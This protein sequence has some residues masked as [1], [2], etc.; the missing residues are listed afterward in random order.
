[1]SLCVVLLKI[2]HTLLGAQGGRYL[3]RALRGAERRR[4]GGKTPVG[5]KKNP[6]F[7]APKTTTLSLSNERHARSETRDFRARVALILI[8]H[9]N[10]RS[11]IQSPLVHP[12]FFVVSFVKNPFFVREKHARA[13]VFRETRRRKKSTGNDSLID[14]NLR[15]NRLVDDGGRDA[16]RLSSRPRE[17][18]F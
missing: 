16:A 17:R 5:R 4:P 10:T 11:K 6:P 9:K 12:F 3:G 14:L 1:M 13:L 2:P 8:S 15:L 18:Y 7:F